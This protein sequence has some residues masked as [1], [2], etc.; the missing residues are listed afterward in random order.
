MKHLEHLAL[1]TL[2]VFAPIKAMIVVALVLVAVDLIT[3]IWAARKKG[4]KIVSAG[5]RRTVT[6][7]F[8]YECAILTSFLVE[9]FMI[10]GLIPLSKLAAGIIA[11]VELKSVLENLDRIYGISLF[12]GLLDKLGSVNDKQV[13]DT[14]EKAKEIIEDKKES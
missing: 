4:E 3:G 6:K 14:V 5:L 13:K 12:K 11:V 9:K 10:D 8:V 7:I 1:A 2:A